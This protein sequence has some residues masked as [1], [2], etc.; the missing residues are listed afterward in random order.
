MISANVLPLPRGVLAA[1]HFEVLAGELVGVIHDL[2]L[3][4]VDSDDGSDEQV[5][6]LD[7]GVFAALEEDLLVFEVE[8]HKWSAT[9][10]MVPSMA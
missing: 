1:L 6:Q 9:M 7:A 10:S 5:L 4:G 3:S 8:L 2:E